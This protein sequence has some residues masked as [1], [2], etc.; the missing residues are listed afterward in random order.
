LSSPISLASASLPVGD[1]DEPELPT[2]PAPCSSMLGTAIFLFLAGREAI[3]AKTFLLCKGVDRN[4]WAGDV[5]RNKAVKGSLHT[6]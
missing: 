5:Y 3:L 2:S 6:T 1:G 4:H